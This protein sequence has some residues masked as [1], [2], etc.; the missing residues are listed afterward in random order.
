MFLYQIFT[1]QHGSCKW[2]R[3][4]EKAPIILFFS[5]KNIPNVDCWMICAQECNSG[6]EMSR[7][8]QNPVNCFSFSFVCDCNKKVMNFLVSFSTLCCSLYFS[9]IYYECQKPILLPNWMDT[10]T[11]PYQRWGRMKLSALASATA[12]ILPLVPKKVDVSV[13]KHKWDKKRFFCL[14]CCQDTHYR[15]SWSAGM[16]EYHIK[17]HRQKSYADAAKIWALLR[18]GWICSAKY[19]VKCF[20]LASHEFES[21]L[22]NW[23]ITAYQSLQVL[24]EKNSEWCEE[25]WNREAFDFWCSNRVLA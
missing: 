7:N 16:L 13:W 10:M 5:S 17:I 4:R 25:L 23:T 19:S 11:I 18:Q 1:V 9:L 21:C 3:R 2:R 8:G 14:L 24:N 20:L 12:T 22:L 6:T 15:C